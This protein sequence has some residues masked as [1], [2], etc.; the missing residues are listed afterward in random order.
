VQ[1]LR[2]DCR[3]AGQLVFLAAALVE[4]GWPE[5]RARSHAKL[6]HLFVCGWRFASTCL[7]AMIK[8][9]KH[10]TM[11]DAGWH[12]TYGYIWLGLQPCFFAFGEFHGISST[13]A[14]SFLC[15]PYFWVT[16][17]V[18][19][20]PWSRNFWFPDSPSLA[21]KS[22]S[23]RPRFVGSLRG[24]SFASAGL[25]PGKPG[26][27]GHGSCRGSQPSESWR[28]TFRQI[29]HWIDGSGYLFTLRNA[30]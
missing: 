25:G 8:T 16:K 22:E 23:V 24:P 19:P 28:P 1:R 2:S 29:Y 27:W 14:M 21:A 12:V 20:L 11:S 6:K 18:R 13:S 3:V 9:I 10:K 5:G 26:L 15:D 7:M 17:V 4:F 30:N